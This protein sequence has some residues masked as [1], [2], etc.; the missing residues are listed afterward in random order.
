MQGQSNGY[1]PGLDGTPVNLPAQFYWKEKKVASTPP[2]F[3]KVPYIVIYH[4]GSTDTTDRPVKEEDKM[5][6]PREWAAFQAGEDQSEIG[7]SIRQVPFLDV[8]QAATYEARGVKNLEALSTASD[9]VGIGILGFREHREQAKAM[10]LA[11]V[12]SKPMEELARKNSEQADQ[13]ALLQAQVKEL[14]D[15]LD[16]K[17][18]AP[19]AVD[20]VRRGPG[21]P[22]KIPMPREVED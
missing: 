2:T 15:K 9:Q 6:Y 20:E 16:K 8:A 18:D 3:E 10:L 7:W 21:R 17:P 12:D 11:A 19:V 22:P 1:I 14:C 5:R 4:T 13:I